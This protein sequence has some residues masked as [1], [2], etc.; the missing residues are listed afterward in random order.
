MRKLVTIRLVDKI[1]PID[2]ADNIERVH[3]DGWQCVAKKGEF[4]VGDKGLYFEVDAFLPIEERFEFLRKSSYK[5]LSDEREGFRLRTVK[6]KGTLSQGL[7]LPM[8]LFP[9][10]DEDEDIAAILNVIKYDPPLPASL[11]GE[12]K[13]FFPSFIRKTDQERI[14]NL[15]EYFDLYREVFFEET[16]KE[17]GSSM[18]AYWN[19][20]FGVCSR[21]LELKKTEGNTL[22]ELAEKHGLKEK[23][24]CLGRN[25]A[26]QGE[27]IGE[28]IQGNKMKI[29]GHR[30]RVFDIYDI[31]KQEYLSSLER[32]KICEE[33]E[34][35]TVPILN[36]SVQVFKQCL[37][38]DELLERAVGQMELNPSVQ[39]EGLVFKGTLECGKVISFKVISNKFLLKYE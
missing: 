21:N 4:K 31:D 20:E 19:G 14:Q 5:K 2:G 17:D 8:T 37:T 7:L 34:L 29:R 36:T 16:E 23:L 9:E 28:G 12:A 24:E 27:A 35:D 22:W 32:L 15:P 30:F 39:R 3:V 1:A 25:I 26:I 10:I 33:L 11:V 18:T 38:M 6:L 13:G